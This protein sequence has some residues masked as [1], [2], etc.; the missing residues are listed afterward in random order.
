MS[1]SITLSA[2]HFRSCRSE[3]NRQCS[4][5]KRRDEM[6][7]LFFGQFRCDLARLANATIRL[8]RDAAISPQGDCQRVDRLAIEVCAPN[9]IYPAGGTI[10]SFAPERGLDIQR[11]AN[12]PQ[13]FVRHIASKP[14]PMAESIDDE[15]GLYGLL[16]AEGPCLTLGRLVIRD[17]LVKLLACRRHSCFP[18]LVS[19]RYKSICPNFPANGKV[20]PSGACIAFLITRLAQASGA[21]PGS[22]S[23]RRP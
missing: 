18:V 19:E 10:S 15:I 9:E 16:L 8:R 12:M 22:P 20:L 2:R 13:L 11:I 14:N 5:D 4:P 7:R 3:G 17:N 21:H 23:H 1:G 6:R